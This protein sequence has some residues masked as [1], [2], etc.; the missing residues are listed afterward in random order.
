MLLNKPRAER[1]MDEFGLDGLV[2]T[3]P[4]NLRYVTDFDGITPRAWQWRAFAVLPRNTSLGTLIIAGVELPR[5]ARYPTW[6]S[7]VKIYGRRH[8]PE[9]GPGVTSW[10]PADPGALL[11]DMERLW[12]AMEDDVENAAGSAI[13]GLKE[14]IG[15]AGLSQSRLGFDDVRVA[16]YL[17]SSGLNGIKPVE[18]TNIF[19][20]VRMVKTQ[21]ELDF[22]RAAAKMNET[23]AMRA[24][25]HIRPTRSWF[26][27][28]NAWAS[29]LCAQGGRPIYLSCGPSEMRTKTLSLGETVTIDGLASYRG[30]HA[31]IGRTI[32]I[33]MPS[34]EQ[35]KKY[36][37]LRSG[38][39][40]V[41]NQ[42]RPGMN[43]QE[44]STMVLDAVHRAGLPKFGI[45]TPHS[46]G[47]EHTDHPHAF[48]NEPPTAHLPWV[49]EPNMT[50]NI[51]MPYLERGWGQLHLED[52]IL[53]TETGVVPLTSLK[54]DLISI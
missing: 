4:L 51:D 1:V 15:E 41:Y 5:L 44:I 14:A 33:G 3:M 16:S 25:Q 43:S 29:E 48:G 18:A 40:Q 53:S 26:E 21:E 54:T 38:F 47:L 17:A 42:I 31:D 36:E 37:A 12:E 52:T 2:A 28:E 50:F 10:S 24:L 11:T 6:M 13:E 23:A 34:L 27:V 20:K 22:M 19:R 46:I 8:G 35:R 39:H 32:A 7:R 9:G 45:A 49:L 30:Y